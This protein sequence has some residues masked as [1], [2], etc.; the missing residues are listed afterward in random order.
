MVPCKANKCLLYPVCKNKQEVECEELR[1]YYW[2]LKRGTLH[3]EALE[4]WAIINK[5]L[6]R[7]QMIGAPNE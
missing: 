6:P 1:E 3:I 4:I 2:N 7:L 5:V